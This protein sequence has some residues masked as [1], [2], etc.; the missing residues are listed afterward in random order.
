MG[1]WANGWHDAW[2]SAWG[3]VGEA[4][5]DKPTGSPGRSRG[6]K[7]LRFSVEVDGEF[8]AVETPEEARAL[9]KAQATPKARIRRRRKPRIRTREKVRPDTFDVGDMADAAVK[10]PQVIRAFEDAV[11]KNSMQALG[12]LR[13]ELE[14]A[15][16]MP[17]PVFT[18]PEIEITAEEQ[19]MADSL[20]EQVGLFDEVMGAFMRN[21]SA[22]ERDAY[23]RMDEMMQR[24]RK[25]FDAFRKAFKK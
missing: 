2:G 5:I 11:A 23:R 8:I 7:R 21:I 6:R 19:Q 13:M 1:A 24:K 15:E 10:N 16:P 3:A 17:E 22:A 20:M 14:R 9:L 25:R 12:V 4:V 18:P